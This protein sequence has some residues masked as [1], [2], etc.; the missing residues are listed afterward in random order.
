MA[1]HRG[2]TIITDSAYF[3]HD[4]GGFGHPENPVRL[5]VI[6]DALVASPILPRLDFIAPP[7]ATR[8]QL[9]SAH[10][11]EWL[12]RLEEVVLSGRS[13]VD[14]SDN[15]V[16]YES[17]RVACHAAGAGIAGVDL[18]EGGGA[19]K[20]FCMVRPPGHHAE[21]I[22]PFGFCFLNNC[23]IAARHWQRTYGRQ[24][25]LILDFDA[26]HG[27]GIQSAFEREA[28]SYYISVHEHPSFSYPGTGYSDEVGFD[29]GR[30]T[31]VNL[32][33]KPGAGDAA[34]LDLFVRKI[35]P[36]IVAWKP[37]A[38][39]VAAGFDGHRLDDMSGLQFSTEVYGTLGGIIHRWGELYTG[40]R[41]L[42]VLEGGY[43]LS[44]LG[45]SVEAYLRGLLDGADTCTAT[46]KRRC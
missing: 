41:V 4:T 17:Y 20:V 7:P 34:L 22:R 18:L 25:I 29:E 46:T 12:F 16:C 6:M 19:E 3:D 36:R 37:D 28:G 21:A 14:H 44:V 27:N 42:S 1:V 43:E 15:Q 9:L 31:I 35:E 32:P 33:L 24:R 45:P 38:I 13:H 10:R 39:I 5:E 8:E 11:E 23:V 30:G 2:V 26:H 40:G